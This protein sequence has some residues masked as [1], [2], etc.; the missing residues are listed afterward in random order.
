MESNDMRKLAHELAMILIQ[1][2]SVKPVSDGHNNLQFDIDGDLFTFHELCHHFYF[3]I[4]KFE[5]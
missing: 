5:R 1:N 3:E 4:E 2:N